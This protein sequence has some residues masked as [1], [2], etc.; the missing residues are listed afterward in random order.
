M[1]HAL[2]EIRF[3]KG[4]LD[5]LTLTT[6]FLPEDRLMLPGRPDRAVN[7]GRMRQSNE[8][9]LA[10]YELSSGRFKPDAE[11]PVVQFLFRFRGLSRS[12]VCPPSAG[13]RLGWI[14]R[15]LWGWFQ[16]RR[17]SIAAATIAD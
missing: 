12:E 3:E 15:L 10:L 4:P 5:G 14:Q 1:N 16:G 6:D 17:P 8:G 9:P 11:I 2:F 13:R 7:L